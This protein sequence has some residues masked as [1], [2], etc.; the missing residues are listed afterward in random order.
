MVR[1]KLFKVFFVAMFAIFATGCDNENEFSDY[2]CRFVF[3]MNTHAHSAALLSAV[4]SQGIFCKVSKVLKDNGARYFHFQNNNEL[5]DDVPFTAEDA[6]VTI[7]LGTNN[8]LWFGLSSFDYDR[9]NMPM[10]YAYDAECPNCFD[11]N[12]IPVRS[13]PLNVNS[14]GIATCAVCHR[15]YN[16]QTGGNIVNGDSGKP[17]RRFRQANYST[18][19]IVSVNN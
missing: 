12:A 13:R 15:E 3:N 10:F 16:M 18:S 11:P 2:P 8:G 5:E 7:I 17:L 19:G 1:N 14:A 4:S 9:N 6:R